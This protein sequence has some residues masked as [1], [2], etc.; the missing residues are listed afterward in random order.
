MRLKSFDLKETSE[1]IEDYTK[2]YLRYQV[3]KG[4]ESRKEII[5]AIVA[6][7]EGERRSKS[8]S[9]KLLTVQGD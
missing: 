6:R 7:T 5:R 9:E 8:P 4:R 2:A 1:M 3:S